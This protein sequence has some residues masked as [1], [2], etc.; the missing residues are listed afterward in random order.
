VVYG[1]GGNRSAFG[2]PSQSTSLLGTGGSLQ[3]DRRGI[4]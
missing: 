3:K 1:Y 2:A 4:L